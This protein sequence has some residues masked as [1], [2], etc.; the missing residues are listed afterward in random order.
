M[1]RRSSAAA[2][3]PG[4]ARHAAWVFPLLALMAA[5]VI[6]LIVRVSARGS[7]GDVARRV[8][9]RAA[10]FALARQST[11]ASVPARGIP[12][13]VVVPDPPPPPRPDTIELR[14]TRFDAGTGPVLVSSGV[15]LPAGDLWPGQSKLVRVYV[16]GAEQ[17]AHVEELAG[18]H[19]DGSLRSVLVQ[20]SATVDRNRPL[21]GSLV[22]AQRR[23]TADIA[24]P[25][26]V[27]RGVPDAVALPSDPAYLLRTGIVGPS[28]TVAEARAMGGAFAQYEANFARYADQHWTTEGANWSDDYYDRALI[29]Y[30]WWARSGNPEYWRRATLFA[31]NYRRDYL[32]KNQYFASPHWS[33]LEGLEKHYLLTGDEAS[34]TAVWRTAVVLRDGFQKSLVSNWDP[35]IRGRVLLGY[36]L[37]WRLQSPGGEWAHLIDDALTRILG[38][39]GADGSVRQYTPCGTM[40]NNF[41]VGL[42]N[43]ALIKVHA[44]YR[45][46]SRIL[47]AV[48]R[49]VDYMWRTQ[50]RP[51]AQGFLYLSGDCSRAG[52]GGMTPAPDLNNMI[53]SGFGWIYR[54][55]GD[56]SYRTRGDEAFAAGVAKAWLD[57]SKQ[58][59]EQYTDSP[60]YLFDRVGQSTPAAARTSR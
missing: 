5:V 33:Q 2:S 25:P 26:V 57:G 6:G 20:F 1:G 48:K 4:L 58:F 21:D 34:R 49:S 31:T 54:Q 23:G 27:R 14:V 42:Q 15:P 16:G 45:A 24:R 38:T 11:T 35:R 22:L 39:V 59:N 32:E 46:D 53:V 51:S 8:A 12:D 52:E 40:Q 47:P 18:R 56:T 36:L 41:M 55:T 29:Y 43:D 7:V 44:Y 60:R 17:A 50:W 37:A 28:V 13:G 30:T 3:R 10:S 9:S 19:S